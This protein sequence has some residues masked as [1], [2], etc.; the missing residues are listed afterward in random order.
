M[1]REPQQWATYR[2][3]WLRLLQAGYYI[4]RGRPRN[5]GADFR[6]VMGRMPA[7][8]V[9][10]GVE[11][12]PLRGPYVLVANHYERPGLWMGSSGMVVAR[13]VYEHGGG[14]LR[15]IAIAE[16]SDYRVGPVPVPR[17]VTRFMFHRFFR[18]F[19]FLPM[20]PER[21]GPLRRAEGVRAA[22][23][24][25]KSGDAIGVFPEGDIGPTTAMIEAQAG[26]GEF[27]LALS[28]TAVLIP[29]GLYESRGRLHV[30]FGPALDIEPLRM[31]S[32]P[33]RDSVASTGIMSAV[34]ALVPPEMRGCYTG[35][36]DARRIKP[37]NATSDRETPVLR[38]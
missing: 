37:P 36:G 9:V 29:V 15:W 3:P 31:T 34:A 21:S 32:K 24:V 6:Y 11:N 38:A 35:S 8:P 18:V 2:I 23:R 13:G 19:G 12:L 14:R 27:L 1:A 16:W 20:E 28:R 17:L 22:L 25:V 10:V 30:S 4:A 26:S 7:A 33:L 5:L